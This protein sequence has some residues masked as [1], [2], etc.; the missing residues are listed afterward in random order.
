MPTWVTS[1]HAKSY[2]STQDLFQNIIFN[3]PYTV[4]TLLIVSRDYIKL[5]SYPHRVSKTGQGEAQPQQ[6]TCKYFAWL[7]T[8]LTCD[9]ISSDNENNQVGIIYWMYSQQTCI[10]LPCS[11][12]S[13]RST[14][15]G[16]VS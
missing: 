1:V 5:V 10:F 4:C 14:H 7:N 13:V 11:Q 9:N 8:V 15:V 6:N 2:N 3:V 16:Y 12:H